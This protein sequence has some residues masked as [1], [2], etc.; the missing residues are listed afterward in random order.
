M[1]INKENGVCKSQW[2]VHLLECPRIYFGKNPV[3]VSWKYSVRIKKKLDTN[4]LRGY[5]TWVDCRVKTM[6][7]GVLILYKMCIF[8]VQCWHRCAHG[9]R[10]KGFL[11]R[12]VSDLSTCSKQPKLQHSSGED[13]DCTL[14]TKTPSHLTL[15]GQLFWFWFW[16]YSGH[17][18]D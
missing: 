7:K 13:V 6:Y 18:W 8:V 17:T 9:H 12:A 11:I 2:F 15:T 3:I 5:Y 10:V 16:L 14:L 4:V 1:F